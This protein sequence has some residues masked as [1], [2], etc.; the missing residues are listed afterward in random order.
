MITHVVLFKLKEYQEEEKKEILSK[1]KSSLEALTGKIKELKQM[2]VGLNYE[3]ESKSYDLCL[4]TRFET[5]AD[6][7][8]Y[9]VHPEHLKVF[10]IIKE[11][12]VARAA[13]DYFG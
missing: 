7:D 12:T 13:V 2:E 10:E 3:L 6:L 9:R 11:S 8:V 1:L 5:L 4:I